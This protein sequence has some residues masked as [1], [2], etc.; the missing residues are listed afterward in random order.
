M[1]G[2]G[3]LLRDHAGGTCLELP[4]LQNCKAYTSPIQLCKVGSYASTYWL[5]VIWV[6]QMASLG[7]FH[8]PYVVDRHPVTTVRCAGQRGLFTAMP[9]EIWLA[10]I[11]IIGNCNC[12]VILDHFT[13][14]ASEP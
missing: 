3:A 9:P 5:W 6:R 10:Y 7:S 4:V 13:E 1:V 12:G 14:I 8:F 2:P 11:V